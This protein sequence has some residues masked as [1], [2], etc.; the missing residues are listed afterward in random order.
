M[1]I[2]P[3]TKSKSIK[4]KIISPFADRWF[5]HQ[6]PLDMRWGNCTFTLD[7][8]DNN[9]D[10]L[11]AY[12]NIPCTPGKSNKRNFEKLNCHRMHTMLTTSEPSSISHYSR[13]FTK[14]FG[15]VL[16]SQAAWAL[17]HEDRIHQQAGLIWL[18]GIGYEGKAQTFYDMVNN[19][20]ES[21][22]HDLA[23]VFSEKK[24]RM[25]LHRKRFN[26][27][28]EM[29]REFPQMH[30]YGRSK[31][32]IALDDK[33]DALAP[34][35]YSFA[36]ENHLEK[37]H[38]TEKLADAFLG[39][40]LPFYAVCPNAADYFPKE[41]FIQIDLNDAAGAVKIVNQAMKKQEFERRLPAILEARR[42]VLFEHNLFA[43]LSREIEKRFNPDD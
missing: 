10:W 9:Y 42:R 4:V 15:C 6:I 8:L 25:T 26:F 41:S 37:H 40:T 43:V 1:G 27:M 31:D 13:A 39:L 34:Y 35:R 3:K 17:P 29:E 14:Q 2:P 19:P 33:T 21:K 5:L 18:Y 12:N 22:Q 11:V 30:V 24:M 28:K 16:T 38:W 7:R 23:I 32:H 36:I 20:P